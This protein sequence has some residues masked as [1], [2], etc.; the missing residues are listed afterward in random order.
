MRDPSQPALLSF[1]QQQL[2]LVEQLQP[3][4]PLNNVLA[5]MHI[6]GRLDV[7]VLKRSFNAVIE[8]HE[9]L[10]TVFAERDGQPIQLISPSL[11]LE[12]PVTD[13]RAVPEAGR[14][15]EVRRLANEAANQPF[16]LKR[17]P[18]IRVRLLKLGE[19]SHMFVQ[20]VHHIIID[21]WSQGVLMR[22]VA[23]FYDAF[24]EGRTPELPPLPIQYADYANWQRQCFQG[25][26]L[27]KQL[28]YWKEKLSGPPPRV[29]LPT[30]RPRPALRTSHGAYLPVEL[31]HALSE[32]L[33]ALSRREGATLFMTLMAA[34]KTLLFRYTQQTDVTTGYLTAGRSRREVEGLIGFFANTLALRVDLSGAPS[35]RELLGR[36]RVASMEASEHQELPFDQLVD[37]LQLERD[38][39]R[40]PL[41]QV[42]FINQ[43]PAGSDGGMQL[44]GLSLRG[45]NIRAENSWFDI[46][47]TLHDAKGALTGGWEYNTDLFDASTISRLAGHYERLLQAIVAN[48]EQR[49]TD[50]PLMTEEERRRVL[51]EWN[52]TRTEYPRERCVHELFEEQVERT[53]EAVAVQYEGAQLTYREL[54]RRANLLARRLRRLGVGP[55][56]RVGVCLERS[57]EMVVALL[58]TLKAGGAYVPLEP[59]YPRERLAYM[60]GDARAPVVLTQER[61]LEMLPE[62]TGQ[63]VCLDSG[64]GDIEREGGGEENVKGGARADNL[65][66]VIYTSGSTGRPK[67]AMNIHSALSNRLLWMQ[68]AYG[69]EEGE[70]VLQ[71]TPFSFDV[72]VWEFFWPLLT[73]ARLVV[74][75]PGGHQDSAYLVKLIEEQQITTVH[76]VPSMLQVFLEEPGLEACTSLERIICSGEAL[77]A[78]LAERC[79]ERLG[80]ELHNLYGPTEAAVDVTWWACRR[81]EHRS[82]IPIGRPIDN[83]RIYLLSPHLHPVPVGVRGELYIA[84]EGLAR[85][86]LGRPEL[87]AE[88]FVPDPFSGEAGARMYRTGDVARFLE[89]G[90]IEYLG[91]VDFQVKIRGLRIE[92]GEIEA[93]LAQHPAVRETVVVVRE[94][95]SGGARLVAYVVA[96]AGQ[97]VHEGELRACVSGKLPEYMVPA[98]LVVLEKLPLSPNGK[99][100]RRA[101][102]APALRDAEDFVAPRT[103]GEE[104]VAGIWAQLLGVPRVGRHDNFFALGGNS[105]RATQAASR[106]RNAF[107]AELPLRW[108]FEAPT[109]SALA[110][111][112]DSARREGRAS[113][114]FPL[115][116]VPRERPLPLS[117]AQQ[118]LWFMDQL[119]PGDSSFNMPLAVR[120]KGALEV[121][122]LEWSLREL[123]RRHESLRTTF[124]MVEGQP[125]QVISPE[126]RLQLGV[127]DLSGLSEQEREAE[128]QRRADADVAQPF[129]LTK[130]P[131][132]RVQLLRLAPREWVLL[133]VLHHIVTDGWS[134]GPFFKELSAL[135]EA[136]S[137][138]R[139]SPLP[140]LPLQY[141]DY[142]V[143]QRS[144]LS[145]EVLESQLAYW[146]KQL[147]GAPAVLELPTDRPR[148]AFRSTRG[149]ITGGP[150]YPPALIQA[151]RGVAQKEGVTF[152]ML[153]EAAFHTLLHRYSGQE[154]ISVGTTI[155]GRTRTETEPL[156]GLFINV[157]VFR[158]NLAGERTFRELLAR[159]REVALGAYEHQDVPFERLVDELEPE[160]S[161][162]HAP[163]FQAVFDM[164]SPVE[165]PPER[166]GEF[167]LTPL[168][169][170]VTTTRFDLALF[171][172]D[173]EDGM[174]G[175]CQYSTDLFE[176]KTIQRMLGHMKT[177]LEGVAANPEQR[178]SKLPLL[179]EEEKR[180]LL[181]E[182]NRTGTEYPRETCIHEWFEAQAERTPDAL[183]VSSASGR[184]TYGELNRR[185]NQ[186]A[187]YLR[188]RGVGPDVVVGLC[189]ERGVELVVGMLGILKAGGAWLPLDPAQP[190]ER[191]GYML[192]DT[193]A[194]VLVTQERLEYEVPAHGEQRVLLD[195]EWEQLTRQPQESPQVEVGPENLAYIIYTSGSTGRPKGVLIEHRSILN[196]LHGSLRECG[197][198][199]GQKVMQF[200][201]IGFDAAVQEMFLPLLNGGTLVFA[202]PEAML[203][204]PQ[205]ARFIKSQGITHL[206]MAT[207]ALAALPYEEDS[208]LRTVVVGGEACPAE[209]ADRWAPGR[210]FIQ[211]YGPTEASITAASMRCEAGKGK[212]PFGK[213]YPNTRLYVLD[214]NL[215][216]VPVGVPG[217]L[218][219]GGAGVGR[220]YLGRPELTAGSFIPDPFG[221]RPGS[222]LYRT[223]DVV[224]YRVDGNLEFVRRADG[225]VKVRGFRIELG[226]IEAVLGKYQAVGKGLVVV[227][228]DVPGNKRL[229]AYVV[230]QPE[231]EVDAE[232]LK[233]FMGE[234]LPEYMVPSAFVVM[235]ALPLT[236]NGKVDRKALPPPGENRAEVESYVAPRNPNE[237]LLAGIWA[238]L[239]DVEKVGI[240][241][242]FF[243]LGGHSLLSVG[244]LYHVRAIFDVELAIRDIFEQPTVAELVEKIAA[245]RK[246]AKGPMAPHLVATPPAEYV[247][248]SLAQQVYWMP[249]KLPAEHGANMVPLVLRL[250]GAL[251]EGALA[252]S[253]EEM[254]RRHEALRTTF[255]LVEGERVQRIH[256]ALPVELPVVDLT[257]LPEASREAEA[258][259]RTYEALWRPF[260]IEHGPLLRFG[261]FRLAESTHVL[262]LGKH[263]ILTD[264]VS[265]FG[266][267]NELTVIYGAYSQGK[268]S[269]LPPVELQDRD[270]TLWERQWVQK[271]GLE[272]LR[273]YWARKLAHPPEMPRLPYDRAP[274][275]DEGF[276]GTHLPFEIPEAL[277]EAARAFCVKEGVTPF[278]LML[279]VYETSLA[280][281]TRQEDILLCSSHANR[282]LA[283]CEKMLGVFANLVLLRSDVS[284]SQ[285]FRELLMRVRAEFLETMDHGDMPYVEVARLPG[286]SSNGPRRSPVQISFTFPNNSVTTTMGFADLVATPLDISL[287]EWTPM[288][289]ALDMSNG[290]RGFLGKFFYRTRL[291]EPATIK[292]L[293]E[294]FLVLLECVIA[295]PEQTLQSLPSPPHISEQVSPHHSLRKTS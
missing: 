268:P 283:E 238:E 179:G 149:A 186:L 30:D 141:A 260:D 254:V 92:L 19:Q 242:N 21:G 118:R 26:M 262:F 114:A 2:W 53:P 187:H 197:M 116:P 292:A 10:R 35:F 81:G 12:L 155:A 145:G 188:E 144:W 232:R 157:L 256:A 248:L 75:R 126:P 167:E 60:M 115:T 185:A 170:R 57:V 135:Y 91:R 222:R 45:V 277:S 4:N 263:H 132:L 83:T 142:A 122:S 227:R 166:L 168:N 288:D 191:L 226:E 96:H 106:L 110:Q 282:P 64:W 131:L 24:L 117:F 66:Y 15:A 95:G 294:Y 84:G 257:H 55:E 171:M 102:P 210:R 76:F 13:L 266:F 234:W 44:P 130:G 180:Q 150:M 42:V 293:Q 28:A 230:P 184:M 290:P 274:N 153:L 214:R 158:V 48:P 101:L 237:E 199:P 181:V 18:L 29:E 275:G 228:E 245:S 239:L 279:A 99:V 17:G 128:V 193:G 71:K 41:F 218:Y 271:G 74:A 46:M 37:A 103:P 88:R 33:V 67:G 173:D 6:E 192:R 107:K 243:D 178:L 258:L 8:R 3:G 70:G 78:N 32:A 264:F 176:E 235:A 287:L 94:E 208:P 100:E 273:S 97:T 112:L 58:G 175:V 108:I 98:A 111:R 220:G 93:A 213:P 247:P 200:A 89:D 85:G 236:P 196:T 16:D 206:I 38:L 140:E 209:L 203:P 143:W 82:S 146:R 172:V 109:V 280:R 139:P 120:V 276:E 160:R 72:S 195:M 272:R 152:F 215:E 221:A 194:L 295:A 291:F 73:G 34:L 23:A 163:L 255:P 156:I 61:L 190:M 11:T 211:Q 169:A 59:S 174:L 127:V 1:P 54:N 241:D 133:L 284:G 31:P 183:A 161:L 216:P 147:A 151:L 259:R 63:V 154:D 177:L 251:D 125:V 9:A 25:E 240:H 52:D 224:R 148:P 47:L 286:L 233:E 182:W 137:R 201:S 162:S 27:E 119:I 231:T 285:S 212:P 261:L 244:I 204:G 136:H 270:F 5:M 22:E 202:P 56:V 134:M 90:S 36:T 86:Y 65:I 129:E 68:E 20:T 223:G 62:H 43:P 253:L 225:Q 207:P 105:L 217:E 14:E 79:L 123:C 229:V 50:L 246:G 159:V 69:L 281:C 278:L 250:E 113:Q 198:E 77:P 219:I 252:R 265:L 39:S 124:A 138:G 87:T 164:G 49:I 205:M 7:A 189:M 51:E 40:T 80:A 121:E 165:G 269:P 267:L 249:G 104:L 289:L